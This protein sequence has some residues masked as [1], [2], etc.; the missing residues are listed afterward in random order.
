MSQ[1]ARQ[2][3]PFTY[4]DYCTWPDD[5]HW[6][7][8]DGVAYAMA[9]APLRVHQEVVF[10]L[11]RQIGNFLHQRRCRPYVAPFDVRLPTAGQ[12]DDR[13]DTVV[14]PDL[15]VICDPAKL[16]DRG[17]RG[18]PDWIIEVLS[19]GSAAHDLL[20]KRDLY[21]RHGVAEYW[22]VHPTDRLLWMYRL[23]QGRFGP[24]TLQVTEGLTPVATLPGLTI[25]WA[26]VFH[27][28][29]PAGHVRPAPPQP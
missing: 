1:P 24:V 25:D 17:C 29:P 16:D 19:P 18:A 6:E 8:I 10:E 23:E 21:Q 2:P 26:L 3:E 28:P 13:T 4:A 11:A 20:R 5:R 7:L 9:P 12:A 27:P 15:A 14:Q 22:L